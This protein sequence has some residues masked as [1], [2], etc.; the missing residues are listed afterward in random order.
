MAGAS[1]DSMAQVRTEVQDVLSRGGLSLSEEL[2]SGLKV[3]DDNVSLQRTLTDP[4]QEP[5][6]RRALI[7]S[8]FGQQLTP[9]AVGVLSATAAA[10]WSKQRDLP[11]AV[12][13]LAV[14]A[15]AAGVEHQGLAGL[16]KLADE[17][18]AFN[19]AV[20]ESHEVQWAL[21]DPQA[22]EAARVQLAQRLLPQGASAEA[23]A[24]INQAVAHPRGAKPSD[25][26]RR[27][28]DAVVERQRRWIADV[29]VARPLTQAQQY[30]LEKG[31]SASFGRQLTLNVE[32][33]AELVGGIRVRV[34]D[35]VVDSSVLTRLNDLE[36]K[37][38]G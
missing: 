4:S 24:L 31:L 8:I 16:E 19:H 2:F 7:Q 21:T 1:R 35:E 30:R 13:Q 36:R 32:T 27:F 15:A 9:D 6:R 26:V 17:L 18:L 10:R 22:S 11:D 23:Q 28:A 37:M 29:T 12:E 38:A 34:G 5:E 33:D 3:F 25:L 20:E 14:Y